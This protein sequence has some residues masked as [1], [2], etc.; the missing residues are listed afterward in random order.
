MHRQMV[1]RAR[2]SLTMIANFV[3]VFLAKEGHDGVVGVNLLTKVQ[4]PNLATLYGA[5][6]AGVDYVIMGAGIPREI[7]G[8]LD[9]FADGRVASIKLDVEGAQR[10]ES[11]NL[12]F[13]PARHWIEPPPALHRPR[14]LPVVAA[15]YFWQRRA[16]RRQ[17]ARAAFGLPAGI[18]LAVS[19]RVEQADERGQLAVR[20]DIVDVYGTTAQYPVRIE[21]FDDEI[22]NI[23][24]FDP[25]TG[26]VINRL[27]REVATA[28]FATMLKG[29]HAENALPQSATPPS[30]MSVASR[31][32][33]SSAPTSTHGTGACAPSSCTALPRTPP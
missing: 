22:E 4:M 21:L 18:C 3:E 16:Q 20:G 33:F 11:H 28:L 25:L 8:V 17:E 32:R 26:E 10:G 2:D 24:V 30:P 23:S 13:D 12:T 1:T 15:A 31:P 9:A 7:P 29:G 6:L 19:E 14:F 27:P 5:M